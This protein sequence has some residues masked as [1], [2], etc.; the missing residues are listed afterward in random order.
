M[1]RAATGLAIVLVLLTAALPAVAAEFGTRD[2]AMAMVR[3]VQQ[4]FKKEG[5]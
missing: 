2:E 3:R 1:S 5:P 4:K